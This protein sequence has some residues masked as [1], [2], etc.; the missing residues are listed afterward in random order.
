[1]S[2]PKASEAFARTVAFK[3][4]VGYRY[5]PRTRRT[6]PW[7]SCRPRTQTRGNDYRFRLLEHSRRRG[8][9]FGIAKAVK[10]EVPKL[11]T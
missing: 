7:A 8:R 1:M 2:D 9:A 6:S 3:S 4:Y 5:V 10:R 11:A